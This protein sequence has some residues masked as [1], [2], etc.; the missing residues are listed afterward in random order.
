MTRWWSVR[1]AQSGQPRTY[2]CPLCGELL[3]ATSDHL[4]IA[5]EDVRARRR[6]AHTACVLEARRR[7]ELPLRDEVEVRPEGLVRRLLRRGRRR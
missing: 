3:H 7:G 1:R 4:L 2:V 5:P 6:H